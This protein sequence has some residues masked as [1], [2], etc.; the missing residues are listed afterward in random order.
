MICNAHKHAA[1]VAAL[2]TLG[3]AGTMQASGALAA[4]QMSATSSTSA[5]LSS[6]DRQFATKAAEGGMAEVEMGQLARTNAES[7]QVKAFGDR[8][9]RDHT[10]AND[11]LKQ[12]ASADG[13]KLPSGIGANQKVLDKL[14]TL[15]GAEF[16]SQYIAQMVSDHQQDIKEFK[17]EAN[18]GHGDMKQ[19]ASD[20]LPTLREHLSLAQSTQAKTKPEAMGGTR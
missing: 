8:M 20:A 10:A 4:G 18:S 14:K 11:K 3:F 7:S 17:K 12:V 13:I 19:F 5:A 9:V 1:L 15:K 2:L 6:A 16:D